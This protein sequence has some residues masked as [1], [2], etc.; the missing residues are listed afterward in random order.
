MNTNIMQRKGGV[1]SRK[2][3]NVSQDCSFVTAVTSA[4]GSSRAS[5]ARRTQE[6][7]MGCSSTVH[8]QRK[9]AKRSIRHT[10]ANIRDPAQLRAASWQN[11][12]SRSRLEPRYKISTTLMPHHQAYDYNKK[13]DQKLVDVVPVTIKKRCQQEIPARNSATGT[14]TPAGLKP[15]Q[16]IAETVTSLGL[17]LKHIEMNSNATGCEER[18]RTC[19]NAKKP[20]R[21]SQKE[22]VPINQNISL[23]SSDFTVYKFEESDVSEVADQEAASCTTSAAGTTTTLPP[24]PVN[25]EGRVYNWNGHPRIAAPLPLNTGYS[26]LNHGHARNQ[27]MNEE[28]YQPPHNDFSIGHTY[29]NHFH[30]DQATV[31]ESW[32]SSSEEESVDTASKSQSWYNEWYQYEKC[33]DEQTQR[34]VPTVPSTTA[35]RLPEEEDD[36][37]DDESKVSYNSHHVLLEKEHAQAVGGVAYDISP[38]DTAGA[39]EHND[40][41]EDDG[42]ENEND[43]K[44][45]GTNQSWISDDISQIRS[46]CTYTSS[47]IMIDHRSLLPQEMSN[48]LEISAEEDD[49]RDE[50][51][52]DLADPQT[53]SQ[54]YPQ[55]GLCVEEFAVLESTKK[56]EEKSTSNGG[57]QKEQTVLTALQHRTVVTRRP[58]TRGGAIKNKKISK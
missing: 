45:M 28:S 35:G 57:W 43:G 42:N 37:E 53:Y 32:N 26:F 23:S 33:K 9:H 6:Y 52:T 18:K 8:I 58:S 24:A 2:D 15:R 40:E 10:S 14:S 48:F 4:P 25:T 12:P 20:V 51:P 5:T 22:N 38:F 21:N 29:L 54:A 49:K 1:T 11:D 50:D 39:T 34:T 41:D 19:N 46:T 56:Y 47:Q 16:S 13:T 55:E 7:D 44:S 31:N 3:P 27:S 30:T 17:R 36:D